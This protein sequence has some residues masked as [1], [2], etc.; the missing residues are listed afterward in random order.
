MN[1]LCLKKSKHSR[2]FTKAIQGWKMFTTLVRNSS[3]QTEIT[4]R[5]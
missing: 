4:M 5:V 1:T 3:K 2:H